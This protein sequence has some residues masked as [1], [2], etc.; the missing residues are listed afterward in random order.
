MDHTTMGL[1]HCPA[2]SQQHCAEV[3]LSPKA[4]AAAQK[5][6]QWELVPKYSLGSSVHGWYFH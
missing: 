6:Q 5:Q 1:P 4:L 2:Y 3:G